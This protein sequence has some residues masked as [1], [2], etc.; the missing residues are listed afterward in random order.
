MN[1]IKIA[2]TGHAPRDVFVRKGETFT[3]LIKRLNSKSWPILEVDAWYHNCL[4]I[5]WKGRQLWYQAAPRRS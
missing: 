1:K 3:A 5:K 2:L 4:P